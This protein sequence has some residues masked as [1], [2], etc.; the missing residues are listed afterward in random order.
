MESRP[1]FPKDTLVM[2]PPPQDFSTCSPHGWIRGPSTSHE[3]SS[4]GVSQ[5]SQH[6]PKS[7]TLLEKAI[8]RLYP[9]AKSAPHLCCQGIKS[10]NTAMS[11]KGL[12]CGSQWK[13]LYC[14]HFLKSSTLLPSLVMQ[15]YHTSYLGGPPRLPGEFKASLDNLLRHYLKTNKF[16]SRCGSAHL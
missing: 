1:F 13:T 2:G 11:I 14:E 5:R 16:R 12:E 9:K 8:S 10:S 3:S 4:A 15:A 6:G 7:S